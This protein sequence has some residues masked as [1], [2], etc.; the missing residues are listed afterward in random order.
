FLFTGEKGMTG[1]ANADFDV[2]ARGARAIRGTA[3]T[4]DDGVNVVGMNLGLHFRVENFQSSKDSDL[5]NPENNPILDRF[6]AVRS[7][8]GGEAAVFHPD[9]TVARTFSQLNEEADRWVETLSEAR[10]G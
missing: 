8:R 6:A 5:G 7:G 2:V 1:G 10:G 4:G 3:G 9:G